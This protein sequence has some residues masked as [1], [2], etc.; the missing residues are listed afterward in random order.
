MKNYDPRNDSSGLEPYYFYGIVCTGDCKP[1]LTIASGFENNAT[2][3]YSS[4]PILIRVVVE[5]EEF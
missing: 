3:S 4:A 2:S 1:S 5:K